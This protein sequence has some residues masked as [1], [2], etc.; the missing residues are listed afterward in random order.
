MSTIPAKQ[1]DRNDTFE[2]LSA[3][4]QLIGTLAVMLVILLAILLKSL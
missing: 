1:R 2:S 3:R 4:E